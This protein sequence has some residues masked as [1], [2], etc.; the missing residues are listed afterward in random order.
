MPNSSFLQIILVLWT[1]IMPLQSVR[2]EVLPYRPA[3]DI[4][5]CDFSRSMPLFLV[6]IIFKGILVI[7]GLIQTAR[8]F[9]LEY[10]L[11]NGTLD[12]A[13]VLRPVLQS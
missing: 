13:L 8:I 1:T 5:M 3:T 7:W 6:F 2:V 11:Y 9:G 4:L 10:S 12:T